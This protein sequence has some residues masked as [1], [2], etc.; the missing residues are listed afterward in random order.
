[1]HKHTFG[2]QQWVERISEHELPALAATV[3]LLEKLAKDD[4]SSLAVLGQSVLHDHGLTSRILRVVNSISYNRGRTQITTVSRAAV[5]LGYD[6][7]KHICITARM[8]DGLLSSRGISE[9][10][11]QRVLKLMACSFHAAMLAKMMLADYA[12][13]TQEEVYIAALL[14][15]LGEVAF[16][17]M[18]GSITEQLE[19]QLQQ[20]E[21][22]EQQLVSKLLGTNFTQLSIGLASHWN[23]GPMLVKSLAEPERRSPEF[24]CIHLA[25]QFSKAMIEQDLA[26]R[27]QVFKLISE[28]MKL[29]MPKLIEMVNH[30]S[31]ET[32]QLAV[33]YG[34]IV[35]KPYLN[36]GDSPPLE[37]DDL[38][39]ATASDVLSK[40]HLQLQLLREL[41][42]VTTEN[43]DLNLVIHT[44]MEGIQR[45]IEMNRVMVLMVNP[46]HDAL[47]L[48]FVAS[49]Q[50]EQDKIDFQL[51]LKGAD[52]VF[53]QAYRDKRNI[54]MNNATGS[55]FEGLLNNQIRR[56][57]QAGPFFLAPLIIEG[58]CIAMIYAD[59]L[60]G[61]GAE[62]LNKEDFD[63]FV[64]FAKQ[65]NLCLSVILK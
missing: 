3:R 15:N 2:T 7:L 20:N 33:S 63:S 42:L 50:P 47:K 24:R 53:I 11:Y 59:R 28:Q 31:E 10:V 32:R 40:Q 61:S 52:T 6:R 62:P 38:S 54:W 12:E 1:M 57:T 25:H 14:H 46:A 8:I 64:H 29:P 37:L 55:R 21:E 35:L 19:Q 60:V 44:A 48:R 39:D 43:P 56:I 18:G 30:C 65:T 23:M 58:R 36:F 27:Q 9:A 22:P 17:S 5:I 4:T 26:A 16:W 51:S 34:A 49:P 41:T 45:G 13:D